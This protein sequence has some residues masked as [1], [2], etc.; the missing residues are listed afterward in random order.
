MRFSLLKALVF[1]WGVSYGFPDFRLRLF[2]VFNFR[3]DDFFFII[4]VI[5][6]FSSSGKL[7]KS[8]IKT[9]SIYFY[10]F[11]Y[12]IISFLVVILLGLQWDS[13]IVFRNFSMALFLIFAPMVLVDFSQFRFFL[14][15][16][17]SSYLFHFFL[18]FTNYRSVL[19]DSV[20]NNNVVK[21]QLGAESLNSNAYGEYAVLLF[22]IGMAYGLRMFYGRKWFHYSLIFLSFILAAAI[23]GRGAIISILFGL[24]LYL[25]LSRQLGLLILATL[26]GFLFLFVANTF[27][28]D[29]IEA[30]FNIDLESGENTG[31]RLVLWTDSFKIFWNSNYFEKF[32][33]HGFGTEFYNM[34]MI[35]GHSGSSHN[36]YL[37]VLL[38]LGV[39]GFLLFC[40]YYLSLLYNLFRSKSSNDYVML[41][42]IP[43]IVLLMSNLFTSSLY[44]GK[45]ATLN[46][47]LI[48]IFYYHFKNTSCEY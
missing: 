16:I 34:S 22:T 11:I 43:L 6:F 3:V 1:S 32:L 46:T 10:L 17:L 30:S 48:C 20:T 7:N 23:L 38:E 37:S 25:I 40:T 5:V 41:L 8:V 28:G 21:N 47:V 31:S 19:V 14:N 44:G 29:L 33:G 13:Y 35:Y 12:Y 15:G 45:V 2:D 4:T 26:L 36:S 42:I 9:N 39:L 18:L 27:Y 24:L